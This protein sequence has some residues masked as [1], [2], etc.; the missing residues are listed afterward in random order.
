MGVRI[1]DTWQV[2]PDGKFEMLA[3]YPKDLILPVNQSREKT[4]TSKNKTFRSK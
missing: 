4:W 3:D 1:E 2:T